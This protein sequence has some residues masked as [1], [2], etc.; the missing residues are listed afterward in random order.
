MRVL[1]LGCG[2]GASS[3]F[4][5][6]DRLTEDLADCRYVL[7]AAPVTPKPHHS[8]G[9]LP[10]VSEVEAHEVLRGGCCSGSWCV[11]A[12]V[13]T[14]VWGARGADRNRADGDVNIGPRV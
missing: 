4:L 3:V 7:V 11:V 14:G 12:F 8:A 6:P 1:D 2:R 13:R 9:R 10:H 5:H